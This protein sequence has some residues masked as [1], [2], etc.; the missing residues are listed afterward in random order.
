MV[1]MVWWGRA[2]VRNMGGGDED[3][4]SIQ[5]CLFCSELNSKLTVDGRRHAA[6]ARPAV[7]AVPAPAAPLIGTAGLVAVLVRR[8]GGDDAGGG[9]PAG[10]G[11]DDARP[12]VV[13]LEGS[14]SLVAVVVFLAE[15]TASIVGLLGLDGGG[16]QDQRR[17]QGQNEWEPHHGPESAFLITGILWFWSRSGSV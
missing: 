15:A 17:R 8:G 3:E 9:D 10:R 7:V 11:A 1:C 4:N 5:F 16:Q 2:I 14:L 12:V 6:A 13:V